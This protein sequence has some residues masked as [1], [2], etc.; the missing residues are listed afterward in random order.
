[1]ELTSFG[2]LVHDLEEEGID[3]SLSRD[4]GEPGAFPFGRGITPPG[5]GGMAPVVGQYAGA[6]EAGQAN[7]IWKKLISAGAEAMF[8]ALDLPTQIGLDSDDPLA[9]HEVGRVGVALDTLADVEVLFDGID[10]E[11]LRIVS[12]TANAISPVALAFFIC[13]CE[14]KGLVPSEQRFSVQNDILKEYVARGT[15]VF[16]PRA[17]LD[18]SVDVAEYC[19]STLPAWRPL[20]MCG[21]HMRGAGASIVHESAFTIANGMEY[22]E[23]LS[24]RGSDIRPSLSLWEAQLGTGMRLLEEIGRFRAMR[25]V[26]ARLLSERFPHLDEEYFKL[27]L[28]TICS[29]VTMTAQQPLNN[30]ARCTVEVLAGLLGGT[31]HVRGYPYDEALGL[32]TAESQENAIRTVQVLIEET[33]VM[34]WC[35]ALGGSDAIERITEEMVALITEEV[36]HVKSIGGP[37]EAIASG[38]YSSKIDYTAY[39]H[40]LALQQGDVRIVG[41]N[42]HAEENVEVVPESLQID[43][44]CRATQLDRLDRVRRNRS[45]YEVDV[46]LIEVR[47]AAQRGANIVEPVIGA[48]RSYASVGEIMGELRKEFGEH[49]PA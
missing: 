35:D 47:D 43:E 5:G 46:A 15:Y 22:L 34:E 38:Y 48:V 14:K 9:E 13:A 37:V 44:S 18:V 11:S 29:G 49:A 24:A 21:S 4:S 17:G 2:V 1:M 28:R 3:G 33:D 23:Q 8:V 7:G 45:Q 16:P 42:S 20:T 41:V 10:I 40:Q 39:A 19:A 31:Q 30:I 25:I 26:W 32:P 36:R 27:K 12:T 6:G